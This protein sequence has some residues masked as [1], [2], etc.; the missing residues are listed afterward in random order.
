MRN[1]A[2]VN[3]L[4]S[5]VDSC[6]GGTVRVSVADHLGYITLNRPA[7]M[8]AINSAVLTGIRAAVT[9]LERQPDIR[10]VIV[11]GEGR[12]F[13]AGGDLAEVSSLVKDKAGFSAFLDYWH[14]SLWLLQNTRLPTIAA[15]HGFAYAGGLEL[16]QVCDFVVIGEDTKLGDQ[17]ANFGL[18]PAGGSTQRLPRLIAPRLAKWMLMS[19]QPIDAQTAFALGLANRVVAE[20]DV[21]SAAQQMAQLLATKSPAC[22]AA[23]KAA[24]QVGDHQPLA[25]ALASERQLAV[26]HMASDDAALGMQAFRDRTVPTF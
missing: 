4:E 22:S 11:H 3:A 12:A 26:D 1:T 25:H 15:V 20:N 23:I 6:S 7:K 16:T 8:N 18:F 2:S 24:I 10:A 17:H 14:A 5:Q 19:G 21:L 9:G 13:S